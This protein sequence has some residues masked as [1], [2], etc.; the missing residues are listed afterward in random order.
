MIMQTLK[1]QWYSISS[2]GTNASQHLDLQA[3]DTP[4]EILNG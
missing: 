4:I 2:W 3:P 1:E